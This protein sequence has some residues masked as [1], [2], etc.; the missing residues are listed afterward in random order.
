MSSPETVVVDAASTLGDCFKRISSEWGLTLTIC[1]PSSSGTN[2]GSFSI[3]S[4]DKCISVRMVPLFSDQ[5]IIY[6]K[7]SGM[8]RV[9]NVASE[10]LNN[11]R[12]LRSQLVAT[13]F[14]P[15]FRPHGEYPS[16]AQ[17][18]LIS[19]VMISSYL[20]VS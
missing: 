13:I 6:V 20:S 14:A 2:Y 3:E 10:N 8:C 17:L 19:L 12:K 16:L 15:I 7:W 5:Y 18:P 9:V 4:G 1:I 11:T